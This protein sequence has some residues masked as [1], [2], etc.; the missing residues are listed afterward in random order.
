[1]LVASLPCRHLRPRLSAD[2]LLWLL[3]GDRGV[4]GHDR[5][6]LRSTGVYAYF[7]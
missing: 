6:G 2:E 1:M 3:S 7:V 5:N 4:W